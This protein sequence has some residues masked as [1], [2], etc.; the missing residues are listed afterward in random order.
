MTNTYHVGWV[1][2]LLV[3]GGRLGVWSF[4]RWSS[5]GGIG[6]CILAVARMGGGRGEG[7]GGCRGGEGGRDCLC[8]IPPPHQHWSLTSLFQFRAE[9]LQQR[10]ASSRRPAN[11]SSGVW[12]R[13]QCI[14]LH[15]YRF[16]K[17]THVKAHE[18][19]CS[20]PSLH[21]C[22]QDVH[23]KSVAFITTWCT[24]GIRTFHSCVLLTWL[25]LL[26]GFCFVLFC[27]WTHITGSSAHVMWG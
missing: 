15:P 16:N 12:K 9:L 4:L 14:E 11:Q 19:G 18:C 22:F 13:L 3:C 5:T 1:V 25:I 26:K 24:G 6:V 8:C 21:W 27:F 2:C 23:F 7:G 20:V 10:G 17:K